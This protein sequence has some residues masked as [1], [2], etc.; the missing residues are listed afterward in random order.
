MKVLTQIVAVLIT[1][2]LIT[3]NT[4]LAQEP[5]QAQLPLIE[6]TLSAKAAELAE[7][8][9]EVNTKVAQ[10]A[11]TI[12]AQL[13]AKTSDLAEKADDLARKAA[14]MAAKE[15]QIQADVA[16]QMRS[17]RLLSLAQAKQGTDRVLMV[18]TDPLKVQDV[19][20]TTEDLN[21]MSRIFDKKLY[22]G[23]ASYASRLSSANMRTVL[24][25]LPGH[26]GS[27]VTQAI[28]LYGYAALFLM[29][30]D[31][32]LSPPPKVEVQKI[33]KDVDPVWE[34]TKREIATSAKT[35]H[36]DYV[37]VR[38]DSAK[39]YDAEKVEQLKTDLTKALKHAANIRNL[40]PDESIILA[41]TG[42]QQPAVLAQVAA[43][44][45][46]T[47]H[48]IASDVE[49]S[50]PS[51]G[52]LLTIRAKKADIDAYAKGELDL[53]KF[54]QRVQLLT[55]HMNLGPVR[56]SQIRRDLY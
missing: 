24:Y 46:K 5:S 55:S 51:G 4:A 32:P 6:D 10:A 12:D 7:K 14:D 33:D 8:T 56:T 45:G 50:T 25:P 9:T 47:V 38:Y 2:N 18:L 3:A 11:R 34:G 17:L 49:A 52:A 1:I 53:D 28:Y 27:R 31:F 42:T 43:K 26:D 30:V 36:E 16:E 37:Y 23:Y 48:V 19:A 41:V 40:K 35:S 54:R 22:P 21:I 39:E 13:A 29:T 15:A 20:A 44:D